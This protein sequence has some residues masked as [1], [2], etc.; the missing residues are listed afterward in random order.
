VGLT[1]VQAADGNDGGNF[2]FREYFCVNGTLRRGLVS[3]GIVILGRRALSKLI[4]G[5]SAELRHIPAPTS[6]GASASPP[7]PRPGTPEARSG[8]V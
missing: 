1:G 7:G 2:I 5:T 4:D 6:R 3:P 8:V